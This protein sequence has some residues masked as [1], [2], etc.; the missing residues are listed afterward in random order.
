MSSHRSPKTKMPAYDAAKHRAFKDK[1]RGIDND[2]ESEFSDSDFMISS[3][4]EK[5][6]SAED[7]A[8]RRAFK[9]EAR[10]IIYYE[11]PD[12]VDGLGT[13]E[14][15][16]KDE[17][18]ML[19]YDA[20]CAAKEEMDLQMKRN[21]ETDVIVKML[22][23]VECLWVSSTEYKERP[24][25]YRAMEPSP[26]N[27]KRLIKKAAITLKNKYKH[28]RDVLG[29]RDH[30]TNHKLITVQKF[31]DNPQSYDLWHIVCAPADS[32]ESEEES[33]NETTREC[34]KPK[35]MNMPDRSWLTRD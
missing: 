23:L 25:K 27:Q 12:E 29:Y 15:S 11:D 33:K 34:N 4:D 9:D 10:D 32:S 1:A 8:R 31:I 14:W 17:A 21:A 19:E 2:S 28:D 35:Y 24:K 22:T 3:K 6:M 26:K 16:S 30:H 5:K 13:F 7:V 20:A 18:R